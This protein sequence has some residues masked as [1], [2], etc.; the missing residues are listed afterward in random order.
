MASFLSKWGKTP[1]PNQSHSKKIAKPKEKLTLRDPDDPRIVYKIS[2]RA[3]RTSLKVRD[4]ER[5]VEVV[6]PGK[7]KLKQAY[8]YAKQN[9][10]WINIQLESLPPAQPFIPDA[11]ILLR[12]E[13]YT[14]VR[15]ETRER[16]RIDHV[17]KRILVP[18]P[19]EAAF[20]GRVR[21]LL[22][23]EA[24][25][26]LES[27]THYY[28]DKLSKKVGKI[29]VRDTSSRWGSC[30]TRNG[31]GHISYSWRLISAPPFVLEYVAAHECA[32]LVEA[33]HSTAFWNVCKSISEDVKPAKAW[34]RKNGALLHA[35]GAEL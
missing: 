15:P 26:E 21:R 17:H 10:D 9:M 16:P 8:L 6:V 11:K 2:D 19:D 24:R 4:S 25:Q 1:K 30:I 20:S 12:G 5:E 28:A 34:L 35:V 7:A 13:S 32:H 29:S 27:A 23:R 22:I 3:R 18:A 33:N 14:L 31:E